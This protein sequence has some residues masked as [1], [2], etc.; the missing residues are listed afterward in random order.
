MDVDKRCFGLIWDKNVTSLSQS[1]IYF[2]IKKDLG[3]HEQALSFQD[4][5]T[6]L[7]KNLICF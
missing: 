4:I 5:N 7:F 6:H 2:T 3:N 1:A